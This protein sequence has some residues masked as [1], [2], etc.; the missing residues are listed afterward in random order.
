MGA[1]ICYGQ[2]PMAHAA[3]SPS[4]HSPEL[5]LVLACAKSAAKGGADAQLESL[6]SQQLRWEDVYELADEHGLLPIVAQ[7]LQPYRNSIPA[8]LYDRMQQCARVNDRRNLLFSAELLKIAHAFAA[9]GIEFLPHK[10]VVLSDY[11]YGS[12]AARR[13]TDIDLIV[14]PE[15]RIKAIGSL[16]SLGYGSALKLK[17]HVEDAAMRHT[18]EWL[19]VRDGLQVDLHWEVVHHASWPSFDMK[20]VWG[21]LV[22]MRWQSAELRMLG[23][24]LLLVVLGLHAAEHEWNQLQMFTDIAAV[25]ERHPK[26]NWEKVE[27]FVSDSQARRGLYVSLWLAHVYFE[28]PVPE[29]LLQ[30]IRADSQVPQIANVIAAQSWPSPEIQIAEGFQWLLFRTRGERPIDRWRYVMSMIL[31]PKIADF[32]A[33]EAAPYFTWLYFFSRPLRLMIRRLHL[34]LQ[35]FRA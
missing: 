19:Y 2:S 33:Y 20:T 15:D 17:Q 5:R 30:R 31:A 35:R 8:E 12:T 24:E 29:E 9:S 18:H 28:E 21:A 22:P 11:L 1:L 10:G 4:V 16:K 7:Q 14:R 13:V 23:P 25:I 3:T 26:L 27:E 6:L 32:E 34:S